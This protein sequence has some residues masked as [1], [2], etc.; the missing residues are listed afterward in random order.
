MTWKFLL[1]FIM[2]F[3]IFVL[4]DKSLEKL[5]MKRFDSSLRRESLVSPLLVPFENDVGSLLGKTLIF[6]L[7][8][9]SPGLVFNTGGRQ[10]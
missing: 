4:S 2:N 6:F 9:L 7:P 5:S 8:L 3:Q 10:L 1:S